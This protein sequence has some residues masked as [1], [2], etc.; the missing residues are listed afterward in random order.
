MGLFHAT[1]QYRG[2]NPHLQSYLLHEEDGWQ[3]FHAGYMT[4]L[5]R[6]LEE[7]LPAIYYTRN[8]PGL[9]KCA[10]NP[11]QDREWM[12]S[13]VIYQKTGE[14]SDKP[15]TR[16]EVLSPAN[17]PGKSHH[18]LY[19]YK[20]LATLQAGLRLIDIDYLHNSPP[21][22]SDIPSD[23]RPTLEQGKTYIYSFRVDVPVPSVYVPLAGADR[24]VFNF[25]VVYHYT[26]QASRFYKDVVVDY[27]QLPL[28]FERYD[29]V[30]QARIQA[31]MQQLKEPS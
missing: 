9:Q 24:I 7:Q 1:N 20:R 29:P 31:K 25:G 4:H 30:D 22:W 13:V 27:E 28:N 5:S 11:D 10:F 14:T 12:T 8:K 23:P 18:K 3:S 17:K 21:I 19:T 2:I 15:V 16:I 26:L 6:A